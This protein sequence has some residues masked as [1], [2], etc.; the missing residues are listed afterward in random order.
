MNLWMRG[1]M[2]LAALLGTVSMSGCMQSVEAG[3][4]GVITAKPWFFGADGVKEEAFPTG[5]FLL[6][7]T[8]ELVQYEVRPLRFD[9]PFK[10]LV[11]SDRTPVD[12]NA[13]V[14]LQVVQGKA[15]L[16]HKNFGPEWYASNVQ[17]VFR[18]MIRDFARSQRMTDL[19]TNAAVTNQG[20]VE[21][22]NELRQY[23][24]SL[25]LP[26][27]INSVVIGSIVPPVEVLKETANTAAQEQRKRT[28][29]E[30]QQAEVARKEA[31]TA[32]AD[33]D[34]AYAS[35]FGMTPDQ[36]LAYR[37][38]ENQ[39]EM[40]ELVKDRENVH[41]ILNAGAGGHGPQPM[42]QVGK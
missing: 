2:L 16:L 5:A 30:R 7:P 3:Y 32:K 31:E 15:P 33:A 1:W 22:A 9:E 23:V 18:T 8:S 20:Q 41:V 25:N 34:R 24:A 19:T 27:T 39:R 13:Y 11:S 42:F 17:P 10:D 14:I 36:Y 29:S 35:K 28:E 26:I 40:I 21:I 12:F 4:E 38:L 37:Q 6:A